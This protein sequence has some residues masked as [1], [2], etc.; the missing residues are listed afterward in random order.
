MKHYQA[1]FKRTEAW[2]K[3]LAQDNLVYFP[4]KEG[5]HNF[6]FKEVRPD[7]SL[8][9]S[10]YQPTI[11]PPGKKLF[12]EKDDLLTFELKADGQHHAQVVLD[13]TNR[14]LAG[15]RPCDVK[16][17]DLMDR[18]FMSGNPDP[19][20]LIRRNTPPSLLL[21][22]SAPVTTRVFAIPSIH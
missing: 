6:S 22:V 3:G 4:F 18:V 14:I 8:D 16:A 1:T 12:P 2:I 15:V 11:T 20:Y 19:H 7:S 13:T 17:I 10:N 21:I 5:R 9:F